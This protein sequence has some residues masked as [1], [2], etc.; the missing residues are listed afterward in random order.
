MWRAKRA[1]RSWGPIANLLCVQTAP[2]TLERVRL[3]SVREE[4]NRLARVHERRHGAQRSVHGSEKIVPHALRAGKFEREF[5]ATNGRPAEVL[6]GVQ[7]RGVKVRGGG[8]TNGASKQNFD[9][10]K[11]ITDDRGRPDICAERF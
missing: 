10:T 5:R 2:P 11:T 9:S 6:K 3:G 4:Y 7:A 1:L 8:Y